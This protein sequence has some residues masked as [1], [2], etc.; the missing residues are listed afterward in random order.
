[1]F[2]INSVVSTKLSPEPQERSSKVELFTKGS[3]FGTVNLCC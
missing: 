3:V 1:M 2:K